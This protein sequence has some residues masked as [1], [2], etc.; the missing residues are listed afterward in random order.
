MDLWNNVD[1]VLIH[2]FFKCYRISLARNGSEDHLLFD[3][4]SLN[5]KKKNN[6]ENNIY[7]EDE[8]KTEESD[9]ES[10]NDLSLDDL[11]FNEY[12][13]KKLPNYEN[14]WN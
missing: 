1:T 5:K 8:L 9:N 2:K 12:D 4:D 10:E 13:N 14:V 7:N 11:E 6:K 3:Y